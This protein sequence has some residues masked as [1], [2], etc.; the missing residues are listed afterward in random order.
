VPTG[1]DD[2]P[3]DDL[4]GRSL[5]GPAVGMTRRWGSSVE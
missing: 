5:N 1:F 3:D 4:V 2:R